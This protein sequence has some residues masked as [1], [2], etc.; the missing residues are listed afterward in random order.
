[1]RENN[2][3]SLMVMKLTQVKALS[4]TMGAYCVPGPGRGISHTVPLTLTPA[5]QGRI[6][7]SV[8]KRGG[9]VQRG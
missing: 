2:K 4:T 1:M 7:T 3:Y 6:H 9:K 5:P 8:H